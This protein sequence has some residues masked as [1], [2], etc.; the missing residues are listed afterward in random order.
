MHAQVVDMP[1]PTSRDGCS[2]ME[3]QLEEAPV[4][5][6]SSAGEQPEAS[7]SSAVPAGRVRRGRGRDADRQSR[8]RVI[9]SRAHSLGRSAE[10]STSR[11]RRVVRR[12]SLSTVALLRS[13]VRRFRQRRRAV[14]PLATTVE[15]AEQKML[16][17]LTTVLEA[18]RSSAKAQQ[19]EDGASSRF[20]TLLPHCTAL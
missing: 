3:Q 2:S 1:E 5:S 15:A 10:R 11:R 19:E 20:G 16:A 7:V 9:G 17:K 14:D 4:A 6:T 13:D 8:A 12:G 18:S